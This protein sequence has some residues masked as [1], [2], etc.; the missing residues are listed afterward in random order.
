MTR[1]LDCTTDIDLHDAKAVM[2]N[3]VKD[4]VTDNVCF[5]N[6][7]TGVVVWDPS[8]LLTVWDDDKPSLRTLL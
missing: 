6:T 4:P 3:R 2:W 5:C 8:F 1:G 7:T